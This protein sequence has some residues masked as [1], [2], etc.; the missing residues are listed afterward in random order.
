MHEL[1]ITDEMIKL[2]VDQAFRDSIIDS[3][4]Q[5]VRDYQWTTVG[6]VWHKLIERVYSRTSRR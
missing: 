2:V 4:R 5:A 3:A 6:P 1:A